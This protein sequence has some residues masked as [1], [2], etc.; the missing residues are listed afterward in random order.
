MRG[1]TDLILYAG[2]G[3]PAPVLSFVF[4]STCRACPCFERAGLGFC[5]LLT[6]L[7]AFC[8]RLLRLPQEQDGNHGDKTVGTGRSR[9]HLRSSRFLSFFTTEWV[10]KS[11]MWAT[12]HDDLHWGPRRMLVN[13]MQAS[14]SEA[15]VCFFARFC[16]FLFFVS[17]LSGAAR[18]G[19]KGQAPRGVGAS[20]SE[21]AVFAFF[22]TFLYLPEG[23]PD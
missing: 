6:N 10:Q 8:F 4:G 13:P 18:L 2:R 19:K 17:H 7:T 16:T 20:T 23:P 21:S 3:H 22:C 11:P 1:H 14:T 12:H 5:I 9:L 15:A